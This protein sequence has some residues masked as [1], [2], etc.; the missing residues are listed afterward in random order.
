MTRWHREMLIEKRRFVPHPA[1]WS[2]RRCGGS[3][4]AHAVRP[5]KRPNFRRRSERD[6]S[7]RQPAL[8][9]TAKCQILSFRGAAESLP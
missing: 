8:R 5:E 6:S 4:R 1:A 7:L 9:M 3:A 2:I